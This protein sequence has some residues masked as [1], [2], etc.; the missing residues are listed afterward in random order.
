VDTVSYQ[1]KADEL[2][3]VHFR[4]RVRKAQ[5]IVPLVVMAVVGAVLLISDE[6]FGGL[7]LGCYAVVAPFMLRQALRRQVSGSDWYTAPTTLSFDETGTRFQAPQRRWEVDWPAFRSWL[8]LDEYLLLFIDTHGETAFTL[9]T[10]AFTAEQL[11]R[12][13]SYLR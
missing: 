5:F 11:S 3:R 1:L 10:R 13:Q 7:L 2:V 9:P 6:T 12:F 8:L 4:L